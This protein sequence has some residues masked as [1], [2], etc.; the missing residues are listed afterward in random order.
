LS[1]PW[2]RARGGGATL[3]GIATFPQ[4]SKWSWPEFAIG[5]VVGL[6]AASV[7]WFLLR[8]ALFVLLL[9]IAV[10]IAFAVL[11]GCGRLP[12]SRSSR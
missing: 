8:V 6:L 9:G 11:G 5:A 7:L 10:A 4:F 2:A 12:W 1:P 3:R